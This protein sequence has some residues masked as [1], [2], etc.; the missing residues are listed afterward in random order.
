M[1]LRKE[2]RIF[3]RMGFTDMRKQINGLATLVQNHKPECPF[4][5]NYF[6][7][8]QEELA[9]FGQPS[10]GPCQRGALQPY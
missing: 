4:D 3:A 1:Q 8:R 6:C 5:G 2:K 9:I 7:G 10:R